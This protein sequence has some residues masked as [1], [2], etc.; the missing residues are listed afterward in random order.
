MRVKYLAVRMFSL[1]SK[2]PDINLPL[3][4]FMPFKKVRN[5]LSQLRGLSGLKNLT[6]SSNLAGFPNIRLYISCT[7]K[8]F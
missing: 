3:G 5:E 6:V 7:R 2:Y 1:L 4:A 8:I